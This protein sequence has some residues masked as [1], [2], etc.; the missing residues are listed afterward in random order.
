MKFTSIS[1]SAPKEISTALADGS[2]NLLRKDE[3]V[4]PKIPNVQQNR[5]DK[6]SSPSKRQI[7][8]RPIIQI[9]LNFNKDFID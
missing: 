5:M 9:S 7:P 6:L 3:D 4:H 2:N 1:I 8:T